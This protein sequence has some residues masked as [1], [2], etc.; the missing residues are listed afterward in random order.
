MDKHPTLDQ[1]ARLD[2]QDFYLLPMFQITV[3]FVF[4]R[5]IIF[6]MNIY[7]YEYFFERNI[8]MNIK[9]YILRKAKINS[10]LGHRE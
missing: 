3:D 6:V 2:I 7:L 10:N 5:Y 1:K 8:F 9:R 4:S